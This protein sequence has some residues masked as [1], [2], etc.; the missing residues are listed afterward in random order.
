M[1]I[2][3][4]CEMLRKEQIEECDNITTKRRKEEKGDKWE[5]TNK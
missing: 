3:D 5:G 1:Q 4:N 2:E